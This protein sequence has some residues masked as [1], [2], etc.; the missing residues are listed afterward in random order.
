MASIKNTGGYSAVVSTEGGVQVQLGKD[1]PGFADPEYRA[2]R[3]AIAALSVDH[4][5]GDPIP[6]V[7]YTDTEHHVWEVVSR[8]LLPK[9][10]Q[11]A[12]SQFVEAVEALSLPSDHIPQ[13]GDVTSQ[14]SPLT[15]FGYQ[16]VAGLAPLRAFYSA[17]TSRTFHSTQYIRHASA[18][19]YTPEPDIIHEVIGHGNQLADPGFAA[20]CEEVGK[21]VDRTLEQEALRFLAKAFWFTLE[22]GVVYE[23]GDIKAYGAGILSSYGEMDAFRKA[24]VVPLDFADMV[25]RDY[26]ITRYQ[27]LVYSAGSFDELIDTLMDFYS[28]YDD[29]RYHQLLG[30]AGLSA[31]A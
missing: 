10:R 3:N 6:V 29:G 24:R 28:T 8:E 13:L 20:V 26:D 14:L 25:T 19:L 12:C 16:P 11:F 4:K 17:F 7:E 18:P 30:L 22:F 9:H 31:E 1:H 21:A 23:K 5:P 15:G 27:P 2:R